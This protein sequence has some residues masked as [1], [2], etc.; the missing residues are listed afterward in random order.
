MSNRD[1]LLIVHEAF[2]NT[3]GIHGTSGSG[4][5]SSDGSGN[6]HVLGDTRVELGA[7]KRAAA[8]AEW[9]AQSRPR[10]IVSRISSATVANGLPENESFLV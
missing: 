10:P 1:V 8:T 5:A 6:V 9:P 3:Q 4:Q 7:F 2:G